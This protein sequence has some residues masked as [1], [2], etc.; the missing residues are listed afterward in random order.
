MLHGILAPAAFTAQLT[1]PEHT[2]AATAVLTGFIILCDWIGS[3]TTFFPVTPPHTVALDDY[4][5]LSRE[6]AHA[7][8]ADTGLLVKPCV[9]GYSG[10]HTVFPELPPPRPLQAAIDA[11]PSDLFNG[12][13]IAFLEAPTGEGKTEA[14]LALA[15]RIAARTGISELFFALPTMATSNQIFLRLSRFIKDRFGATVTLTHSQAAV[16]Q[17]DL[18][19]IALAGDSDAADTGG[20]SLLNAAE[21]FAGSKKSLLAPFGVGTVDQVELAGL[22]VRHYVLRL[23]A[24]SHKVVIIDEVHAYDTYMNTILEHTLTWL[25]QLGTSVILLSATLPIARHQALA[26]S[27]LRGRGQPVAAVPLTLPYPAI[28]VYSTAQTHYAFP[29]SFRSTHHVTVKL[30]SAQTAHEE[31]QHLLALVQSGGAV[32]RICNRVDDAQEIYTALLGLAPS[33]QHVLIHARFPL[34][35]RQER[36]QR[37]HAWLGKTT[38]RTTDQPIIV[39]GT[40]VL[41]QSLDYDVDVMVTDFAPMD[42]LLQR[43]GRLHRHQRER[44]ASLRDPVLTVVMRRDSTG[45]PNW[46][47]WERL[48]DPYVLWRSWE[49]LTQQGTLSSRQIVLPEEY[50][51]LIESVYAAAPTFADAASYTPDVR[52]AWTKLQQVRGELRAKAQVQLTPDVTIKA[53]LTEGATF[54]FTED[55]SGALAGWQI[56][57]TRLGDRITVLPVYV[58]HDNRWYLDSSGSFPISA[59]IRPSDIN[60]YLSRTLP[61]S[62]PRI[63]AWFRDEKRC[64]M[65]WR[66]GTI[67]PLLRYVYPLLL[68]STGTTTID[69]RRLTLDPNVGLMIEKETL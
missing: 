28:S 62:D 55:E 18:R 14:A 31:A 35:D 39:I 43:A 64:T 5:S 61:I 11:I 12:P 25:A 24:L 23:L 68:D 22:N 6:R 17:D 15:Q 9:R 65:R 38:T 13:L 53:A 46:K 3:N 57:K 50:R 45:R 69:K 58:Q 60:E 37:I 26:Q 19:R 27:Y 1:P 66:W 41:E 67:P 16:V 47:R 54:D 4:C 52:A 33:C 34:R 20:T 44:P 30:Q 56:A 40:Q 8:I 36:E 63:V 32:A 7:S 59:D 29:A 2:R 10:F 49:T 21:W 48:Y 51:T 42:L